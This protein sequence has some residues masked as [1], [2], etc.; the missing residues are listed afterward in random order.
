MKIDTPDMALERASSRPCQPAAAHRGEAIAKGV[1]ARMPAHRP[2]IQRRMDRNHHG[3]RSQPRRPEP[4]VLA[5]AME[6]LLAEAR[7][8]C[9]AS[10]ANEEK[11]N[12]ALLTVLTN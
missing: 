6:R 4:E 5:Y 12:G 8:M 3:A 9:S 2:H 10:S 11:R 1:L 7:S